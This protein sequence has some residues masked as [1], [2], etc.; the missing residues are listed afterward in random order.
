MSLVFTLKSNYNNNIKIKKNNI[1]TIKENNNT[2][3]SLKKNLLSNTINKN[4]KYLYDS[5]NFFSFAK[6]SYG[7]NLLLNIFNISGYYD[8]S[9][10]NTNIIKNKIIVNNNNKLINTFFIKKMNIIRTKTYSKNDINI[11]NLLIIFYNEIIKFIKSNIKNFKN[12]NNFIFSIYQ[13]DINNELIM[14]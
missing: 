11:N 1:N 3:F 12:N 10:T 7:F 14:N 8:F 13:F 2:Y 6:K 9:I 5:I 4:K